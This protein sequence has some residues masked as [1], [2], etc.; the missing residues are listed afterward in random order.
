MLIP[1]FA[2]LPTGVTSLND[3]HLGILHSVRKVCVAKAAR[4]EL[5]IGHPIVEMAAYPQVVHGVAPISRRARFDKEPVRICEY[6]GRVYWDVDNI[7]PDELK[8]RYMMGVR[9]VRTPDGPMLCYVDG[10][11]DALGSQFNTALRFKDRDADIVVSIEGKPEIWLRKNRHV[12]AGQ[13]ILIWYKL[14]GG[15]VPKPRRK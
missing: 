1:S 11:P 12:R 13:E 6:V 2:Y 4:L 14:Y 5:L 9:D 8:S 3:Q 7:S 15:E 10:H